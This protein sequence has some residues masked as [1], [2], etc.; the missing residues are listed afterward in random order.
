MLFVLE[1]LG[2]ASLLALD[3]SPFIVRNA[4]IAAG[5]V[6]SC[7]RVEAGG[8]TSRLRRADLADITS[9][10]VVALE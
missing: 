9:R 6:I 1:I 2:T 5:A 7:P 3:L 8:R 4:R 10:A